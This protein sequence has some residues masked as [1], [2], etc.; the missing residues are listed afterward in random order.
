MKVQVEELSPIERKLSIEVPTTRVAEELTRA[1]ASLSRQVKVAGF[2]PGKVPRR[3]LEQ[4]FR[5][6]VENDVIQRVVQRAYL[7]A[8]RE[9]NVEAVGD[10]QVTNERLKPDAPFAFEARV[11]VKPKVQVKDYRALPLKKAVVKVDDAK[12]TEQLEQMRQSLTRLEPVADRDVAQTGDFASVD[13]FATC[14]GKEFAG[15]RAEN[16]TVEVS[17]GELV[18]AHAPELAGVKIGD[19]KDVEFT[20]PADYHVE[21]VKGK[22]ARFTLTLK[23]LKI[24]VAPEVNDDFAKEVGGGPQT[25]DELKAKIR[26]DL[27]R[28]ETAKAAADEREELIKVLV[29]KNPLDVPRAMIERAIDLMLQGAMRAMAR[30]GIDPQRLGLDLNQLREEMRPR[31]VNEVKGT[32]LFEAV[33]EAEKIEATEAEVEKKIEELA[34]QTGTALSTVKKHFKSPDERR[35]LYLRLREEKAIE[36]LKSQATYS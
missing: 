10:P 23:G 22:T 7:D 17:P 36:F 31:A 33:A 26:A 11:E 21:E 29:E 30:S 20:F 27:E 1:Y 9:H 12:I 32:L 5:S 15:N 6:E 2:R 4:R 16:I 3:I 25:V 8:I 34:E 13:Y 35:G 18:Q 14:E 24:K 28:S 19:R